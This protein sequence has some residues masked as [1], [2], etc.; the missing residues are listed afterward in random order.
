MSKRRDRTPERYIGTPDWLER[1]VPLVP[2]G[3]VLVHGCTKDAPRA[4]LGWWERESR[5]YHNTAED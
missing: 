1:P 4:L 5:R 2:G 3:K